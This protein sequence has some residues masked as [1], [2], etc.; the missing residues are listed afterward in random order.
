MKKAMHLIAS[1]MM[2]FT[3]SAQE[4]IYI[5]SGNISS[6]YNIATFDSISF[7]QEW[8]KGVVYGS[9]VKAEYHLGDVENIT[10][11]EKTDFVNVVYKGTTAVITNPFAAEGV[12]VTL[13]G[14]DVVI[15]SE[16]SDEVEYRLSGT[17]ANGSFKL[18]S[19]KKYIL[20]LNNANITNTKG[21]AI[22]IQSGKKGTIELGSGSVNTLTDSDVYQT[23]DGEDMKATF[24]SEGQ[25]IFGGSG[26][27]N[28]YGKSKH[29]ICSD[30]YIIVESG[31]INVLSAAS[32]GLHANAYVSIEGG[33]INITSLSD[34]IDA[35]DG[36]YKQTAGNVVINSTTSD[37][38]GIKCDSVLRTSGRSVDMSPK[39]TPQ[40][41]RKS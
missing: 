7:M 29:G 26:T 36:Y 10:F 37:V 20:T 35:G 11:E 9:G 6:G 12:S 32:D 34:G 24:F 8:T 19:S 40:N 18:Y 31:N 5:N 39:V 21:A 23:V 14:A 38:K 30:D 33:N 22:N 15:N 3:I 16:S 27:L 1:M 13:N 41:A 17:T 2:F 4:M 25:L 28:V